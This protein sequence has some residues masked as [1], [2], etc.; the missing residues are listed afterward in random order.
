MVLKCCFVGCPN[1]YKAGCGKRFYRFTV[2]KDRKDCRVQTVNLRNPDGSICLQSKNNRFCS[3]HF[4][5]AYPSLDPSH[6]AFAPSL[7]MKGENKRSEQRWLSLECCALETSVMR[8]GRVRGPH[9]LPRRLSLHLVIV[10]GIG[11]LIFFDRK[12]SMDE[13]NPITLRP[14]SF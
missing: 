3:D 8:H 12:L 11:W 5:G 10:A 7:Q 9:V 14:G 4:V 13:R 1:R 6:P 2:A